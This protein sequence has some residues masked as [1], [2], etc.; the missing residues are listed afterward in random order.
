MDIL[1][2]DAAR[3]IRFSKNYREKGNVL[4]KNSDFLFS[5]G[6]YTQAI[7]VAPRGTPELAISHANRAIALMELGNYEVKI[8]IFFVFGRII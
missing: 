1:R 6:P 7:F 8:M 4:F 2:E 5:I 3:N